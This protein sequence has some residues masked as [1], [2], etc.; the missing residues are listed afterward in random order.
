MDGWAVATD[1]SGNVF[2]AGINFGIYPA[3]LGSIT[4][5]DPGPGNFQTIIAKYDANGNVLWACGTRNGNTDLINIAADQYGDVFLFGTFTSPSFQ[6]GSYTLTNTLFPNT[7]Y[8]LVKFD[9]SGN[10]IWANNA[11]NAQFNYAILGSIATVLATGG[12]ATDKTGN[13]YITANFKIPVVTLGT[14]N[15]INADPAGNSNDIM[16]VKY[17]P[18][19]N[20]VW[21]KS[22]GGAKN[23]EAYCISVTSAGDLYIAGTFGSPSLPFG[24]YVL[25]NTSNKNLAFIARFDGSG[26]PVWAC[27]SG[28]AGREYAVGLTAD[29]NNNVYLTGGFKDNSISFSG[30]TIPNP[31]TIP[32]LYL[33]KFDPGNNVNW[34]KTISSITDTGLGAWGYSIAI[35]QCGVVWVSGCMNND[36]N[37]DGHILQRPPMSSDPIFIAGYTSS[38]TYVGSSALASGGDDQNGIACDASGNVYMSCDYE[39]YPFSI[40]NDTFPTPSTTSGELMFLGKYGSGFSPIQNAVTSKSDFCLVNYINIKGHAGYSNYMWNDGHI[41][42][43]RTITDTGTFWVL[44]YDSCTNSTID[45]FVVTNAC[46]CQKSLFIPNAFTPNGD[47]QDDVFYPRCGANVKIIKTFRVYNRWGELLFER[48]QINP[49]DAVN[50]WDGTYK[51]NLPLPDVYVWVVEAICENGRQ[52]NKKGSVTVIR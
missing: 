46:D 14:T 40:G 31:G 27:S 20:M 29:N 41:G 47:G 38:G 4:I 7:Q 6:I 16:I 26:N 42:Q 13:V 8:F 18:F 9:A 50:A 24:P 19:G 52:V 11:G 28:G 45:T 48:E 39:T 43:T 34:Y 36:I 23:D 2:V 35:S 49:N 1:P 37:I 15:L 10:V 5:P 44:G 21:A 33:V 17:D 12:V 30:T 32:A 3:V 25:T 22:A 51:G